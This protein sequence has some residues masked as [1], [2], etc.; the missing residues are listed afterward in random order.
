MDFSRRALLAT[1]GATAATGLAGCTRGASTYDCDLDEPSAVSTLPRP[2]EGDPDADV[3][4]AVYEDFGSPATAEWKLE[5]YPE[6]REE[7]V[8]TGDVR[9]EH[10]DFPM[11]A[12][13]WSEAVANAARGIQD[14]RDEETFFAFSRL[15]HERQA[16]HS[17]DVIGAIAEEIGADPCLAIA[18]ARHEPYHDVLM[19]DRGMAVDDGIDGAP[20]VVVDGGDPMR[21][22][23]DVVIDAIEQRL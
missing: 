21:A 8:E 9:Y 10:W 13:Q 7:Y 18:D 1:A 20:T 6:I 3:T 11:P 2:V 5:E 17:E 12:S 15:A 23:A 19:T 14:R 4:L 22:L 16:D